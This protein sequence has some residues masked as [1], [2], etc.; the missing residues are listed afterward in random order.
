MSINIKLFKEYNTI[1]DYIDYDLFLLSR[2]I[3]IILII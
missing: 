2:K 3:K 1:L